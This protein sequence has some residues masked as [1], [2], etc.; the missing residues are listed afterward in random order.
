MTRRSRLDAGVDMSIKNAVLKNLP[1]ET[2]DNLTIAS[3]FLT[4]ELVDG[5]GAGGI[6]QFEVRYS[7]GIPD[8]FGSMLENGDGGQSTR[9]GGSGINAGGDFSKFN[10][11]YQ[12]LQRI[13]ERNSVLLRAE[14]QFSDDLLVSLE[15]FILGGPNNVRAYPIAEFLADQGAF[16]SIEWIIN[17]GKLDSN[18]SFTVSF[19]GDY[20]YGKNNDPLANEI[21]DT[22]LGGYGLG[23]SFAH[24]GD[25]G[26]QF[27]FRVD[28]ATPAT[29]LDPSD[30]DD[31]QIYGQIS[32][33]F[34]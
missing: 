30:G 7:Q 6:N 34:K 2:E 14:G 23:L 19:F 5:F 32:Y 3:L 27:Q 28:V 16:A 33:T 22:D 13:T 10:I 8:L 1:T 18:S 15:Q 21:D 26:N 25:N 17:A 24:T 4:G 20:A 9:T 31:P 29:K 12:R 11:R